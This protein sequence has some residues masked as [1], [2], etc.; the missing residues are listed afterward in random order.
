MKNFPPLRRLGEGK[1]GKEKNK[2]D[3]VI[4]T[5]FSAY[6][7]QKVKKSEQNVKK[8]PFMNFYLNKY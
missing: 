3:Y 7:N 6:C 8:S 2:L 5:F 1:T 4:K